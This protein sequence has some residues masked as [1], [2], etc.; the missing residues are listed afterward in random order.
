MYEVY[1]MYISQ[2]HIRQF[3][4]A[5]ERASKV[6]VELKP[7]LLD[8]FRE[9]HFLELFLG[10]GGRRGC[11]RRSG[12]SG[13]SRRARRCGR[14]L[15]GVRFGLCCRSSRSGR[16]AARDDTPALSIRVVTHPLL[17]L[18]AVVVLQVNQ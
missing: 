14:R 11:T 17:R 8:L 2:Q 16:R 3:R 7:D 9:I 18:R 6:F 4:N 5:D 13:T 15:C 1:C 10:G 12:G